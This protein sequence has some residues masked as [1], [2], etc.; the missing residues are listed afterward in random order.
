MTLL[1]D[2][3]AAMDEWYSGATD[4]PAKALMYAENLAQRVTKQEAAL[5]EILEHETKRRRSSGTV[6]HIADRALEDK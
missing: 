2:F 3:R 1:D 5:R 6:G 4:D